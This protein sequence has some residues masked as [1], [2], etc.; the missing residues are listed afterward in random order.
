MR[1]TRLSRMLRVARVRQTNHL[2]ISHQRFCRIFFSNGEYKNRQATHA[3]TDRRIH[4]VRLV[5]KK[6]TAAHLNLS[7]GPGLSVAATSRD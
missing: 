7:F 2:G 5:K 6:K 4:V 1:M 3:A